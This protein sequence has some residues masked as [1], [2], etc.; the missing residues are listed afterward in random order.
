[1]RK[2]SEKIEHEFSV[3]IN[4]SRMMPWRDYRF[5]HI[6]QLEIYLR[7]DNSSLRRK[8]QFSIYRNDLTET[9]DA[10]MGT[11]SDLFQEFQRNLKFEG[12]PDLLHLDE[13]VSSERDMVLAARSGQ[14]KTHLV[15]FCVNSEPNHVQPNQ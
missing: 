11:F 14:S 12:Q 8:Y 13:F 15:R 4:A 2:T 10:L 3:K 5:R 9:F 6:Y 1:V 7:D